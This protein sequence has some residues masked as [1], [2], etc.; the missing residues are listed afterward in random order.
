MRTD[1]IGPPWGLGSN[2]GCG[3]AR[4]GGRGEGGGFWNGEEWEKTDREK[5]AETPATG[6]AEGQ[7]EVVAV[8][9]GPGRWPTGRLRMDKFS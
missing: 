8:Y 5:S 9:R 1:W 6:G 2:G 7:V 4:R 3:A